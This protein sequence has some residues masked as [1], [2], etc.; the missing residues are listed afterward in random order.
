MSVDLFTA[1]TFVVRLNVAAVRPA[2]TMTVEGTCAMVFVVDSVTTA[3][4]DGAAPVSLMVPVAPWPPK[5]VVGFSV[6]D[7]TFGRVTAGVAVN[8][9]VFVTPP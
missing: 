4:P 7:D 3:P 5:T 1:T 9:A 8:D 6:S 2:A